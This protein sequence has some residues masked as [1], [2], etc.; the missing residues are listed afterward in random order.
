[1]V[2][3]FLWLIRALVTHRRPHEEVLDEER[4]SLDAVSIFSNQLRAFLA[5]LRPARAAAWVD[6]LV[7]GSVRYL[8]RE[9]LEAAGKRG[10]VRHISETPDEYSARLSTTQTPG[11]PQPLDGGEQLGVLNEAYNSTRYAERPPTEQDMPSIRKQVK[12]LISRWGR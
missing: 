3:L 9:F 2:V 10:I 11:G 6:P 1:V 7:P 8:Y 12:T 4:E 5:G